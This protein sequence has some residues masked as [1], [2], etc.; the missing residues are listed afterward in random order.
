MTLKFHAAALTAA[1]FVM[2]FVRPAVAQNSIRPIYP[3]SVMAPGMGMVVR[4]A[5]NARR[6]AIRHSMYPREVANAVRSSAVDAAIEKALCAGVDPYV[7]GIG[8]CGGAYTNTAAM[9]VMNGTSP[10]W[11]VGAALSPNAIPLDRS[12]SSRKREIWLSLTAGW[13]NFP[14]VALRM[15]K[16][17]GS[18]ALA[19]Y[20]T[21]APARGDA[22]RAPEHTALSIVLKHESARRRDSPSGLIAG[23]NEKELTRFCYQMKAVRCRVIV[24]RVESQKQALAKAIASALGMP[25]SGV[26]LAL[27]YKKTVGSNSDFETSLDLSSIVNPANNYRYGIIPSIHEHAQDGL[28]HLDTMNPRAR[29]PLGLLTHFFFDVALGKINGFVPYYR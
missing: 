21:P 7:R 27:D 14:L 18:Q 17:R 20:S 22:A 12:E 10:I 3:Q 8:P 29:F 24:P 16:K 9:D 25:A 15:T 13:K 23:K 1:T 5:L 26:Y 11:K 2:V 19:G 6:P 4:D 28:I